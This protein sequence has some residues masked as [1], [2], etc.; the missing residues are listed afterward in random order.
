MAKP[1]REYQRKAVVAI[2]QAFQ[3]GKRA[4]LLVLPTG[5]GK[6]RILSE[7]ASR[8]RGQLLWLAHRTE[9]CEQAYDALTEQGLLVGAYGDGIGRDAH[10][11]APIQVAMVQTLASRGR[12]FDPRLIITDEAHHYVADEWGG[13]LDHYPGVPLI[14]A[15]ATPCRTDSRGLGERY[16]EIIVGA[17]VKQLTGEGILTPCRVI[18]PK[19]GLKPGRIAQAPVDAYRRFCQ[20]RQCIVFAPNKEAAARFTEQFRNASIATEMVLGEGERSATIHAY[21]RKDIQVLV[22]VYVLT[23]G[24][25]DPPTSAIIL[26]RRCSSLSMYIQIT[27][28]GLRRSSGKTDCIFVD[29]AGVCRNPEFGLPDSDRNYDLGEE[30]VVTVRDK[31]AP[32]F[33][34]VCGCALDPSARGCPACGRMPKEQG[35]PTVTGD[36][37][38]PYATKRAET[39]EQR[40]E[41]FARWSAIG[42]DKRYSWKWAYAKYQA[43]YG[44]WP[45]KE[46]VEASRAHGGNKCA[47]QN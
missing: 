46:V 39:L 21:R 13:V 3:S 40:A 28:R 22:N 27:G 33:C 23:E 18:A 2:W 15:T 37:L 9:L 8:V 43:V 34:L 25:D 12:K 31:E 26:A 6:T 14:G 41:T 38:V 44:S 36:E 11:F 45:S 35:E 1:L 42:H 19:D 47:K 20:G 16:D 7:C 4:P 30:G 24:F 10:P 29:L 5:G 32:R 17:T